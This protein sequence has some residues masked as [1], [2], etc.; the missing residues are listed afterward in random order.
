MTTKGRPGLFLDLDGTLADSLGV[1]REI[2]ERFLA[3]F[4]YVGSSEEFDRLNGPSLSDVLAILK[5]DYNLTPPADELLR[6]YKTNLR[7]AYAHVSPNKGAR[8]LISAAVNEGW[9]V[10]V[11]SSN[12]GDTVAAWLEA[13]GL[14]DSIA[15]IATGDTV[16]RG[17]P[18]PDLYIKALHDSGCT[19]EIS[20][21][22]E[23]TVTG[24]RSAV[25]AGLPTF[26]LVGEGARTIEWPAGVKTIPRLND[27]IPLVRGTSASKASYV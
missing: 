7:Q 15:V 24:V 16:A 27:L 21:A 11:V 3:E 8:E 5:R 19:A 20:L 4:G 18:A 25:G 9:A 26:A 2:Y 1:M 6:I 10:S 17:K 12:V 23:D 13:V 22:V 14:A